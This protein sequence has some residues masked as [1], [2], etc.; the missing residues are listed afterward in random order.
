MNVQC[1]VPWGCNYQALLALL[2]NPFSV[3]LIGVYCKWRGLSTKDSTFI[4][5][6]MMSVHVLTY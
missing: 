2:K 6:L 3:H 4:N 1:S 5:L